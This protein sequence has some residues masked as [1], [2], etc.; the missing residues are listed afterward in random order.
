M[1]GSISFTWNILSKY[2]LELFISVSVQVRY[3]YA[4]WV[5]L[6]LKYSHLP[7]LLLALIGHKITTLSILFKGNTHNFL[8]FT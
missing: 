5:N 6:T 7:E 3:S 2:A 4:I 1:Y 8:F